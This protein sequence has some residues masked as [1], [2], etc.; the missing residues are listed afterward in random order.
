MATGS[1][2]YSEFKDAITIMIKIGKATEPP[3]IPN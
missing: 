3:P 1:P 2:P